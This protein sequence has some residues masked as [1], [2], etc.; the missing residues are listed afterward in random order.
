M[1]FTVQGLCLASKNGNQDGV[2][3]TI[4]KSNTDLPGI[5]Q[6]DQLKVTL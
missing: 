6:F 1:K 5:L 2:G 3:G 4:M